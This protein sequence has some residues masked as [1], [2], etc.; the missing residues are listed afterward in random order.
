MKILIVGGTGLI[1]T[2]ISRQLLAR[3]DELVL[4]NRGKSEVRFPAGARFVY[5]ERND[6]PAFEQQMIALCNAEHF[7]AVIDMICFT[8]AQAESAVRAFAGVVPHYIFC[9]T[10]DVYSK[11]ANRYPLTE[12]EPRRG[13]NDY[14]RNKILCE[15]LFFE[16][17]Q[18]GTLPVTV[19]RPA[20]TYGEGGGIV[21]YSGWSRRI[22][23][24]LRR[25]LPILVHGDGSSL[26]VACHIEDV[27]VAFVNAIGNR[28]ALGRAY[29]ATGEEWLTWNRYY[30]EAAWAIGAPAPDLVHIPTDLLVKIAPERFYWLETN[31]QGN[32]IFDNSA[33]QRDLGFRYTIPWAE[34]VKRTYD[35]LAANGQV[36]SAESDPLPDRIIAAWRRIEATLPGEI[37]WAG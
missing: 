21:D 16:A 32:N 13:N 11:P 3:G 23:D 18:R 24:R 12:A 36:E 33:A 30:T 25:G 31:F 20:M 8:P 34:G 6:F 14:G 19:M 29:H 9:S 17:H 4:F 28:A 37:N 5:G 27:A 26:W 10:V 35:W 7:D 22:F 2:A 1:S 15:D